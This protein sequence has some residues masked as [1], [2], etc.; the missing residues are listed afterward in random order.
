MAII[1]PGMSEFAGKI[2]R[3]IPMYH[4]STKHSSAVWKNVES[5]FSWL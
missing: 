1:F 5:C 3:Q 2:C 4:Y